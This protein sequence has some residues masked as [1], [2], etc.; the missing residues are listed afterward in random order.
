MKLT[1]MIEK[2]A[3]QGMLN[4]VARAE[5]LQ[6]AEETE[7]EMAELQEALSGELAENRKTAAVERAIL[8]GGGKNVK[9]ILAL[10]DMEE[11]SYDAKEGLKGLDL[12]EVKTEAPYLFY[13][14]TEKKK[15]TGAPMTRQKRKED[16]IRA[17]FRRGLGR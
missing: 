7:Q 2:F 14:K 4:G 9:A 15:G 17:A 8:E 10:L 3:K 16:E 11:I 5:L 6:A 13:E 1:Q 12:E